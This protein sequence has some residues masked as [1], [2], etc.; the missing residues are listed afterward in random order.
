LESGIAGRQV[1]IATN[2]VAG[3]DIPAGRWSRILVRGTVPVSNLRVVIVFFPS[4]QEPRDGAV[5]I[6]D[7]QIVRLP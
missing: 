6:D 7:V 5:K 3:T 2:T 1:T 4:L